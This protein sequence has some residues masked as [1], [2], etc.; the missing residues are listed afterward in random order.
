MGR[1]GHARGYRLSATFVCVAVLDGLLLWMLLRSRDAWW[2]KA[3][4]V[5]LVLGLNFT[6]W[7]A[8]STADGWPSTA[9]VPEGQVL[10][11]SVEED[12]GFIYLVIQPQSHEA[13]PFGFVPEGT[14]PRMYR[15]DYTREL[16]AQ[17]QA[18]AERAQQEG[19]KSYTGRS[20]GGELQFYQLPPQ[21]L[22]TKEG[23]P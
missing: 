5:V 12:A 1:A 23:T 11:C 4:A 14:D 8:R 17:C 15:L 22:P 10:L 13:S 20:P 6:L 7:D 21:H 9:S 19:G 16:H 3:A 2:L 18:A